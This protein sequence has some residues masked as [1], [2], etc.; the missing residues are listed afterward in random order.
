MGLI[1]PTSLA[2]GGIINTSGAPLPLDLVSGAGAA[3][4][5]RRTRSL[6]SGSAIRVRRSNDNAEA[7]IGFSG[8]ALDTAA[9]LSHTGA[10]S[11]FVVTWYDQSGSGR[12]FTQAT[13]AN[14][15]RIVNAG[16]IDTQNGKPTV[17]FNGS[18]NS[19]SLSTGLD[20]FRNISG[21]AV[22]TA[23]TLPTTAGVQRILAATN[24]LSLSSGR[25]YAQL[26][27]T[28]RFEITGRRLDA[29]SAV[30]R[31]S[32]ATGKWTAPAQSVVTYAVNLSSTL[33]EVYQNGVN[34]FTFSNYLTA[35][36][37]SNTDSLGIFLGAANALG[38]PFAG[39]LQELIVYQAAQSA[40]NRQIV[41]RNQGL[42][43]GVTVA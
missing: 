17:V 16:T 8:G 13:T 3:Y 37:T 32:A 2:G 6:Y 30:T 15:A 26:N 29:D 25:F 33:A 7:D 21:W 24:G 38:G 39:N 19:Y 12:N 11:G 31:T 27:S 1:Y 42:Y 10:N 14:Q 36:S 23:L 41:E 5:L 22:N 20:L 35:G 4:S 34:D 40:G 28:Q 43:Y 9:L 18:T